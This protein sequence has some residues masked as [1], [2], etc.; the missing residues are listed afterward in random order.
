MG[1]F[2]TFVCWNFQFYSSTA[3]DIITMVNWCVVENV[4][5][6]KSWFKN[7]F[8]FLE[9]DIDKQFGI[10]E[11]FDNLNNINHCNINTYTQYHNWMINT[12]QTYWLFLGKMHGVHVKLLYIC[13]D[14]S[15]TLSVLMVHVVVGSYVAILCSHSDTIVQSLD[16]ATNAFA[17]SKS[18]QEA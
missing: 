7:K 5:S 18:N 15:I 13:T 8:C 12:E 2:F 10:P 17:P 14:L 16:L 3:H 4:F 11:D 1:L 9:S 6:V